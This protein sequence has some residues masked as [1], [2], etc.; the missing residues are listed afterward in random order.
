L[1]LYAWC[2]YRAYTLTRGRGGKPVTIGWQSF[3][4]QLGSSYQHVRQFRNR[5]KKEL[6]VVAPFL[7]HMKVEATQRGMTVYPSKFAVIP[8]RSA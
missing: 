7:K 6:A 8:K 5:V 3:M 2:L 4:M 1:D